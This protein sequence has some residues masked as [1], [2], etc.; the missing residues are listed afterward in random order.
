MVPVGT[1]RDTHAPHGRT[2]LWAL[3]LGGFLGPFGGQLI[4]AMLPEVAVALGTTVSGAAWSW[5][6]YTFSMAALLLVSGTLSSRWGRARTVRSAYLVYAVASLVCA[7]APTIGWF[8]AGRV[9]QGAANAFTTPILVAAIYSAVSRDRLGHSLGR[10]GSLQA[11][12]M[13]FAPLVGGVAA[14]FDYRLAFVGLAVLA[15][16]LALVPPQDAPELPPGAAE[17]SPRERWR[18]LANAR[19]VRV[20]AVAF[21]FNFTSAGVILLIAL[22][23]GDRFG[24]G[25]SQRGFVIAFLGTAG[26]LTATTSG[27]L[28]DRFGLR[29]VGLAALTVLAVAALTT[30]FAQTIWGLVV[31]AL[32]AGAATTGSRVVVNSLSVTSTPQNTDG[33]TSMTMSWMFLGS[34][35][36]PLLC[37][38]AYDAGVML[39]FAVTAVGAVVAGA[40]VLVRIPAAPVGQETAAA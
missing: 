18:S 23:G 10:F 22:L 3:D 25:P 8:Y 6:A 31:A 7:A 28:V 14:A 39:G 17:P 30:G 1:G 11:A 16:L 19:L 33:A 32:I 37:I 20:C 38:P 24:L 40:L 5:S 9:L 27:K 36:A 21:A 29:H 26:L 15:G 2:R 4:I 34:A 35:L 13:A 12:G